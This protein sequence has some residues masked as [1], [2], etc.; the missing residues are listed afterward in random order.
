[1][2]LLTRFPQRWLKA[3]L[4]VAS[5]FVVY[6][7]F[8]FLLLP[9]LIHN[10]LTETLADVTHRP[11]QLT[12]LKINPLE[13]S[14]TLRGLEFGTAEQPLA[15][16]EQVYVNFSI[17]SIW[18]RAYVFSAI[19]LQ[20]PQL[21]IAIDR[22]GR[23]NFQEMMA[24]EE[25]KTD[26]KK[27]APPVVVIQSLEVLRAAIDFNDQSRPQPFHTH[28]ATLDFTL[29]DFTTRRDVAGNYNLHAATDLGETLDWQGTLQ[30]TPF[31]SEGKLQLGAIRAETI[32]NWLGAGYQFTLE[33]G[34]LD[35]NARYLVDMSGAETEFQ[36]HDLD[37][38]LRDL[39]L[40]RRDAAADPVMVLPQLDVA[41]LSLD[42]ARR[43]V[44]I[45]D[46]TVKKM[47]LQAVR[48]ADGQIDLQA[49]FAKAPEVNQEVETET[50]KPWQIKV[51]SAQLQAAA[52]EVADRTT[53]PA[54]QWQ[55]SPFNLALHNIELGTDKPIDLQLDTGINGDGKTTLTGA[56]ILEPLSANLDM[57]LSGLD[58]TAT[59]PY[60]QS[61]AQ[62]QLRRGLL[63]VEGKL[64]YESGTPESATNFAG[65]IAVRQL[66]TVDALR[67]EEFLRW[68]QLSAK[69]LKYDS[70]SARLSIAELLL[71]DPYLRFIIAPD[72]TTNL[73]Q[74]LATPAAATAA[75]SVATAPATSAKAAMLITI[76]RV[77]VANGALNFSDQSIKPSFTTSIQQLNG[78]ISGLS[79]KDLERAD[80]DL[81]GKVDRYAPATITG[82]INP[83][84]DDA[85]TD[86]TFDFRGIEMSSFSSYSGKFA[87][88]KIDKGKLNV[89][90]KYLLSK[91]E[92]KGENK[93]VIDQLQLGDVVA[94]ADATGLPVRL[95]VA[96]LKD[97]NGVIDLDLLVSGRIDDPDF[98]YGHIVW[99]A[100]KNVIIKVATAPFKALAALMGG[101]EEGAN[102]VSFATGTATLSAAELEKLGKL[103]RALSQ[104]SSLMLE[105]RGSASSADA[106][107]MAA[108]ALEQRLATQPGESRQQRLNALY[109]KLNGKAAETLLPPLTEGE[110]RTPE[111][112]QAQAATAAEAALLKRLAVSEEQLRALAQQRAQ[113]I[114]AALNE[115]QDKIAPE[116]IFLLD[117]NTKAEPGDTV[118]VPLS[119]QAR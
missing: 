9:R 103:A 119:L 14:A 102:Q 37:V 96:I 49:L 59:Q 118:V 97:A 85:Y 86:L 2:N 69:A 80:V 98:H 108:A 3:V 38:A 112:R 6:V 36:L 94:S 67:S 100:L 71:S 107:A 60:V 82:K 8:G 61:A 33:H 116:R 92:L 20:A 5:L 63:D 78:T 22:E 114:I 17:S 40:L 87:G 28:I 39:Q 45:N 52:L 101:S 104:R 99:M 56:V 48:E 91:K 105:V 12:E 75:A 65:D 47:Q 35:L 70:R 95:A 10:T 32:W 117:I 25:D 7:G 89:E 66:Q 77:R 62:L 15:H 42:L 24:A 90:L 88:Y 111:Q 31:R 11:V 16:F 74:I 50:D 27:G 1:M 30:A 29:R 81:K 19:R 57:K 4:I 110:Q 113:A 53:Q 44:T 18:H 73:S 13:L 54:A 26:E 55:L 109:L 106:S 115:G 51:T 34:L 76:D 72:T 41:G 21:V 58:L 83:L 43:A 46:L 64:L 68:E 79:S 84:S 23:F 93:I